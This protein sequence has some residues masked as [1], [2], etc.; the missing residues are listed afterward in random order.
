[1]KTKIAYPAHHFSWHACLPI[2]S[3]SV[4]RKELCKKSCCDV[5]HIFVWKLKSFIQIILD[6]LRI[7]DWKRNMYKILPW[8]LLQFFQSVRV[9]RMNSKVFSFF[10]APWILFSVTHT[11]G[12]FFRLHGAAI[13]LEFCLHFIFLLSSFYK[14]C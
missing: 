4:G 2:Y 3:F 12:W 1:M 14:D 10:Q 6:G 5:P 7:N 8:N 13:V 11:S 9:Q